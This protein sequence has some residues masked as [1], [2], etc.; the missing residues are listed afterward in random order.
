MVS[1]VLL[2]KP[3]LNYGYFKK[4]VVD[5]DKG[6][7][8]VWHINVNHLHNLWYEYLMFFSVKQ[9]HAAVGSVRVS[10]SVRQR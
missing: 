5:F 9:D 2:Q 8:D 6:L 7:Y 3:L 1:I 10:G 4:T